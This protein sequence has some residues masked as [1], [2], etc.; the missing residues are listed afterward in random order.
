MK[1]NFYSMSSH[2]SMLIAIFLVNMLYAEG[3][4]NL[5]PSGVQ[6]MR[7]SLEVR[8]NIPGFTTFAAH[9]V[10]AKEGERITLASS[11]SYSASVSP[12]ILLKAPNGSSINLTYTP[13]DGRITNRAAELAGPLLFSETANGGKYKPIYYTVP[14]GGTG[15]YKIEF[16]VGAISGGVTSGSNIAD[17]E[18]PK[19]VNYYYLIAAWDISVIDSSNTGFI[20]GRVYTNV[21]N[22]AINNDTNIGSYGKIY[23]LTK[24]GYLYR[25]S[26]NGMNGISSIFFVNTT[27]VK[28]ASTGK[29]TYQSLNTIDLTMINASVHSPLSPDTGTQVTHKLFYNVPAISDFPLTSIGA[30]PGGNT[31]LKAPIANY[32]ISNIKLTGISNI[33]NIQFDSNTPS[34]SYSITIS[35]PTNAFPPRILTGLSVDGQNSLPWDGKDGSGNTVPKGNVNI[36][37]NIDQILAAEVHFPFFDVEYNSKGFIIELLANN[38]PSNVI[39]DLVYWND[40]NITHSALVG[41]PT[42]PIN[43]SHLPPNNST[44]ISSNLNGHKWAENLTTGGNG[45]A[46]EGSF[47]NQKVI[48]T[49][50]FAN[51]TSSVSGGIMVEIPSTCTKYGSLDNPTNF[52]KLGILAKGNI[53]NSTTTDGVTKKWPENVPNGHIVMDSAD[54]G[55]VITHMTTDQRDLLIPVKGMMIYNTDLKCVQIYRGKQSGLDIPKLDP[56]RFGWQCIERGCNE[57]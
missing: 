44:G 1:K 46:G 7:A 57:Y 50:T 13:G 53:T 34:S 20:N 25:V 14:S 12:E 26:L 27:G 51:N 21:F 56:L 31:W 54:K 41:S 11:A 47:G 29:A 4:K 18:W 17:G 32:L 36:T 6:G 48:D 30:V 10:Y 16:K 49:W 39:S 35:S 33:K 9:Y 23:A 3:S 45:G 22:F 37:V 8:E 42:S 15:I 38:N 52:T 2:F 24:D 55:F 5:Y 28:D 40:S 43:N 19:Y